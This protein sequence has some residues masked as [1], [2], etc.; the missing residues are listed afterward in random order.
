MAQSAS[1]Y[2]Y[3]TVEEYF[4]FEESSP[5]RH[6]YIGGQLYALAGASDR[7]NE[8]ILNIA[9]RIHPLLRGTSCRVYTESMRL[10]VTEN[11]YYYPDLMVTCDPGDRDRLVR[12]SPCLIVEVLSPG[13]IVTDRREKLFAYRQ[14]T[15]LEAYVMVYQDEM[16]VER[17]YR[18]AD[19]VW[20]NAEVARKGNVPLPCPE[21]RL[22]LDDIYD[23]VDMTQQ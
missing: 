19:G 11:I 2:P 9:A 3:L 22:T 7:H 16:R 5:I 8:I 20:R 6:E 17:H 15:S 1:P 13:S 4:A 14:I 10:R 18:D 23:G 12:H 21:I